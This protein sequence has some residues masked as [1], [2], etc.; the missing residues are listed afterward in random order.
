MLSYRLLQD[1]GYY[2]YTQKQSQNPIPTPPSYSGSLAGI[3][4]KLLFVANDSNVDI[5]T[6]LNNVITSLGGST[7]SI[8]ITT[9]FL[10]SGVN[11]PAYDSQYDAVMYWDDFALAS[12]AASVLNTYYANNKGVCLALFASSSYSSSLNSSLTKSISNYSTYTSNNGL[13]V[14]SS[15]FPILYG[16]AGITP[17]YYCPGFA[18][19]NGATAIGNLGGTTPACSY[20]EGTG[21]VGR[22]VDCNWWPNG[23]I[24]SDSTNYRVS[25]ATLQAALWAA[26]KI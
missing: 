10:S 16:V 17:S 3:S 24:P 8:Q 12:N 11:L 9:T 21:G 22:R 14:Q 26:R 13:Y 25:R 2:S 4:A 20:L 1:S 7:S 5:A 23:S 6:N 19:T 18:A 15:S